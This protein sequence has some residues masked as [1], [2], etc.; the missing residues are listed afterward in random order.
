MH[1]TTNYLLANL[2][3]CDLITISFG[4]LYFFSYLFGYPSNGFRKVSCK[5]LVLTDISIMASGFSL[6]VLAVE[7][8]H[9]LLK[10]FRAGLRLKGEYQASNSSHLD[11]KR[12]VNFSRILP[13]RMGRIAFHMYWPMEYGRYESDDQN[14]C[15]HVLCV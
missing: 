6:T 11:L 14:L 8:Y 5:I 12:F 13:S 9:A 1:T 3:A 10:P 7:R 15:A 4:P 2:A